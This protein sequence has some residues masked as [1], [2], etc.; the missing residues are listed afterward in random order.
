[1][2]VVGVIEGKKERKMDCRGGLFVIVRMISQVFFC[3]HYI[4]EA[5]KKLQGFF[6]KRDSL[7]KFIFEKNIG[8]TQRK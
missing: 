8:I 2:V 4:I 1:M 6:L 7:T 3:R 5:T